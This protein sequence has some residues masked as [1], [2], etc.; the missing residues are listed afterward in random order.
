MTSIAMGN[1][2]VHSIGLVSVGF[3][4][5][6]QSLISGVISSIVI[7]LVLSQNCLVQLNIMLRR[8]RAI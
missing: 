8:I 4:K 5:W 3:S 1:V 6:V 2:E 7:S